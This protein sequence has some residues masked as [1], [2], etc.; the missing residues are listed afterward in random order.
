MHR[1]RVMACVVAVLFIS[2]PG[3][4]YAEEERHRVVFDSIKSLEGDWVLEDTENASVEISY[5]NVSASNIVIET[6]HPGR[7]TEETTVHYIDGGDLLLTHYCSLGPQS[8]MRLEKDA[9]TDRFRYRSFDTTNMKTKNDR[10][11]QS[12]ELRIVSSTRIE[13]TWTMFK[14]GKHAQSFPFKLKRK[15]RTK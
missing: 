6:Y 2:S 13:A 11:M 9:A 1:V 7:S 10:Y 5:R 12:M 4:A 14:D 3:S 8:H 15:E